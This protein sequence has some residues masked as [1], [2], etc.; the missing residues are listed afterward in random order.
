MPGELE[1]MYE[2]MLAAIVQ[3]SEDA[4]ASKTLEG[5]VT[6]WNKGAENLF[7]YTAEEMIGQPITRIIP[8]N[9]LDEEPLILEK[10]RRGERMQAF[11]TV[12]MTKNG[13]LL[14]ISLTLSPIKD[15]N[16]RI[17][18]VSKIARNITRQ[19]QLHDELRQSESRLRM[20]VEATSLGTWDYQP[21][22][23]K[24]RLSDEC[25]KI[26]NI[27]PDVV[28]DYKT[29]Q[30]Y[31]HPDDKLFAS[32]A[33]ARA[34]DP[35]GDGSYDIQVRILRYS[36]N[37]TRWVRSQGKVYFDSD[38]ETQIIIGTVFDITEEKVKEQALIDSISLFQRMADTV[39]VIIWTT[40]SDGYSYYFNERWYDYTGQSSSNSLGDGWLEAVHPA[41]RVHTQQLFLQAIEQQR[42]FN[43]VYRLRGKDGD[44]RSLLF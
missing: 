3:S 26:Y 28:I 37:E 25:R 2:Q 42:P 30:E 32:T 6:S 34:M 20:A 13:E 22:N 9:R 8:P 1:L 40:R 12:R 44:Y 19:K 11:D 18:G 36:D 29:F 24:L 23:N 35:D 4:I 43:L 27:P 21:Q 16:G 10:I 14:H 33:I 15:S 17:V 31:T 41:D 38:R 5:I 7:G 39:P